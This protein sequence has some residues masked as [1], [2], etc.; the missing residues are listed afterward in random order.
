M[1]ARRWSRGGTDVGGFLSGERVTRRLAAILAADVV[2]YSRLMGRDE[3]GTVARLRRVRAER[4]EPVLL[5]RGGRIVKLTG[6]GALVEFGSAVDAVRA[7]IEFQQAVSAS[8]AGVPDE[9][10]IVFRVGIHLGDL[11]VDGHDLYG[12]GVNIAARLESLTRTAAYRTNIITSAA[13][14]AALHDPKKFTPRPLAPAQVKGRAEPV[15]I[16]AVASSS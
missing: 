10:R 14:L 6:D 15:E 8:N 9:K 12:D 11:V 2:G 13:T 3:A 5:R 1:N 16:F 4:L 7:A